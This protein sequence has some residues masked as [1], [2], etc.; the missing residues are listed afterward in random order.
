M[1]PAAY[2]IE[3][4]ERLKALQR[5]KAEIDAKA[6][7]SDEVKTSQ[8]KLDNDIPEAPKSRV[9][10]PGEPP[11]RRRVEP[12]P[13]RL[14]HFSLTEIKLMQVDGEL[15]ES[16]VRWLNSRRH[17]PDNSIPHSLSWMKF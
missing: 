16:E 12:R 14:K 5:A 4:I 11:V 13:K 2:R 1:K 7:N 8:E 10:V 17:I 15:T 9:I 6:P 3:K